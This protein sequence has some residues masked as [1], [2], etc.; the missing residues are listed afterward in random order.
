MKVEQKK[1][2]GYKSSEIKYS[3]WPDNGTA[4]AK[5]QEWENGEGFDIW[6]D[7]VHLEVTNCELDAICALAHIFNVERM[8][9]R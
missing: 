1:S 9:D 3:K 5:I 6:L 8:V 4:I 2:E 7:G